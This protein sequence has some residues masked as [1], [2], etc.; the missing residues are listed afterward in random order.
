MA[1]DGSPESH[2]ALT[3][4]IDLARATG[5]VL[6]ILTVI[7]ADVYSAPALMG[8]PSSVVL[9]AD[10]DAAARE[11]ME[12][13][14]A[15][16]LEGIQ[17]E[18]V[19]LKSNPWREIADYAAGLDLL[20]TGSRGYGPLH[21]VLIGGTSGCWSRRA[22][23]V[24]SS[25]RGAPPSRSAD[26]STRALRPPEPPRTSSPRGDARAGT[27]AGDSRLGVEARVVGL[28][29]AQRHC[30]P[31]GTITMAQCA[32]S[33]SGSDTLPAVVAWTGPVAREPSTRMSSDA[34]ALA[35]A[36]TQSP[37]RTSTSASCPSS[38]V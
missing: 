19:V 11:R 6:A 32:P 37:V 35:R 36:S 28:D 23:P 13:A 20:L 16:V 2:E 33:I 8:G 1:F 9:K 12:H 34:D 5:A 38:A 26:C 31:R 17:T 29:L 22:L 18:A 25:R 7:P 10:L 15:D 24:K 3:A 4:A 14:L 27:S 21:A 30:T